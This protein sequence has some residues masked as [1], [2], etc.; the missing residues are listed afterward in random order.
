M[1][2]LIAEDNPE[3]QI[4]T[5][6]LMGD[7]GYKFDIAPNGLEA[8]ERAERSDGKY[9]LCMMDINMPVM[10]GCEATKAIRLKV[11]YLPILAVSSNVE[12]KDKC[13]KAGVDDFLDKCRYMDELYNKINELTVKSIKMDIRDNNIYISKEM[14]MDQQHAQELRDL[15]KEGLCK[16]NL[17]GVGAHD[18]V[19]ITHKNVPY[20]ISQDFIE[21][22]DEVSIFIDRSKEKPVECHLYK[23]SCPMPSVYIPEEEYEEKTAKEDKLLKD[24]TMMV[25]KKKEM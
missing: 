14:P 16:I 2:I 4:F 20:K 19:V 13:L 3:F 24:Y 17:R 6:G 8:V 15:A 11:K 7:W 18:M 23:S 25:T 1:K 21:D 12:F 5:K 22:N 10:D 9:D